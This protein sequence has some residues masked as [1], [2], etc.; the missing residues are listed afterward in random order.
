MRAVPHELMSIWSQMGGIVN[1]NTYQGMHSLVGTKR[2]RPL[3]EENDHIR[4]RESLEVVIE[5]KLVAEILVENLGSDLAMWKAVVITP[6]P[7][8]LA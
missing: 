8:L 7:I 2:W 3:G 1:Q 4:K 5:P 6:D